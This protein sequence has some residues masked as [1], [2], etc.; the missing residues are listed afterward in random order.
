MSVTYRCPRQCKIHKKCF[1][2]KTETSVKQPIAVLHKCLAEKKDI[3]I[4]I[5]GE[6][7]P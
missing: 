7:P 1:I 3:R 2:L 5:G 4:I 6:R